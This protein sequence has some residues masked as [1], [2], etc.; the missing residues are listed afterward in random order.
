MKVRE[1][2]GYS[3]H[4]DGTVYTP[5]G[6]E[7][8]VRLNKGKY[9]IKLNCNNEISYHTYHRLRYF[10]FV[11]EFDLY[12]KDI[13][14]IAKDGN[15]TNLDLSNYHLVDRRVI[16][17]RDNHVKSKLTTQQLQEI[18]DKYKGKCGMNQH[19][20]NNLYSYTFL[21]EQYGVSKGLIAKIIR[22]EV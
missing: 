13:C 2:K 7:K 8:K 3:F 16:V 6:K 20:M 12:N 19:D 9:E 22:G 21:A 5:T 1:Y 17:N 4:E 18:R 10:L 15:Y 14:V 11:E